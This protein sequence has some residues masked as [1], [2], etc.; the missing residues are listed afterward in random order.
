[1]TRTNS[2][3]TPR[4]QHGSEQHL[5]ERAARAEVEQSAVT[6][7]VKQ[8]E[9]RSR[10][11]AVKR[12]TLNSCQNNRRIQG[13]A[14]SAPSRCGSCDSAYET[15]EAI[16]GAVYDP[17]SRNDPSASTVASLPLEGTFT[18]L[19]VAPVIGL[20]FRREP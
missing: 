20:F 15:T 12:L 17:G 6:V 4:Q 8:G 13:S 2:F 10:I 14:R 19:N 1:M 3:R 5:L 9:N 11:V 18:L 7:S 16:D